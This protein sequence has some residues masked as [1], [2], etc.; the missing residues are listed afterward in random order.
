MDDFEDYYAILGTSHGATG[1]EIKKAYLDKCFILHPDR[2]QGAPE[3]ARIRA[4]QELV[5]VNKAYAVLSNTQK[6]QTYDIN[7]VTHKDKPKPVV[8]PLK[9]EFN[10]IR[11]G[12]TRSASFVIRN[13]GGPYSKISIPNPNTWVRLVKWQSLSST[14]ELPLQVSI[15]VEAPKEGKKFLEAIKVKLDDEES[16]L[17]VIIQ[18]RKESQSLFERIFKEKKGWVANKKNWITVSLFI[19]AFFLFGLASSFL[20]GVYIPLWILLGFS[21]IFSIQKW[22]FYPLR[23]YKSVGKAYRLIL[24]L[25]VLS[26]LGLTIWSGVKLFSGHF[27]SSTWGGSIIF[28]AEIVIFIWLWRVVVK[29]SWRWPSMKLTIFSLIIV[30]VVLAFA[31]IEPLKS[32]K[33][34]VIAW[35]SSFSNSK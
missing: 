13:I 30:A 20:S 12:E 10:N 21:L 31:G 22:G 11:P 3:S 5:R 32:Y 1:A 23:K 27:I 28:L 24:N 35:F 2:L 34:N 29:N 15:E 19:F 26:L 14:D 8:E 25:S 18:I 33:D 7:W 17:P 9:I 4:E 6:R 16:R